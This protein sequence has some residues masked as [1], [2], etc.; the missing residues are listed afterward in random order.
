VTISSGWVE[1]NNCIPAVA[2]T[3]SCTIN[4][5]FEPTLFGPQT[6]AL[7]VTDDANNSP[8]TVTLGGTG[9]TPVV[10]LSALSLTFAGQAVSTL[11]APQTITLANAG[12]GALTPLT[13]S[14]SGDFA[15]TNT[16]AA[17]VAPNANCSISVTFTPSASGTRSGALTLTD[18]ASNSPQTVTL[19]GTGA[20]P[21]VNL[22][23]TSL[24]FSA[25]TVS[26][27]SG[28]QTITLTNAGSAVLTPL[29]FARTGDFAQTNTCGDSVAAGASCTISV[30]FSPLGAGTQ[31]GTI[32]V[33]D[34]AS[35]SPQ[36]VELSGTGMDFS[37]SSTTTSQ[38]V[39][40]GQTANYSL[41]ESPEDGFTQTVN[42]ACTGAPPLSTCSLTPSYLVETPPG[43]GTMA[44]V[45]VTVATT[46]P[47]TALLAPPSGPLLPPGFTGAGR[48]I[49]LYGLLG[50]ASVAVLAATRKRRAAC[51]LAVCMLLALVWSACGGGSNN[52]LQTISGTPAGTY[53]VSVTGT[54]ATTSTLTH[55][56][57]F[58]L[59]VN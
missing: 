41:T 48:V 18:N 30:T 6:G 56:I 35:N 33:T 26:T 42:F 40:A 2:A 5:S 59:T 57:Q 13:I 20:G 8:Q 28:P 22:S 54:A 3:S 46:A 23:S 32:T 45:A 39:T 55:T 49:W 10:S 9:L 12:N 51:L 7:A 29:K 14:V 37:M 58:T 17:S 47:S 38:T 25:Q 1:S 53:T 36:T 43:T 15:E 11:S 44:T 21:M 31:S 16:C 52:H 34:N 19:S 27:K 4:A 50:L 24:T